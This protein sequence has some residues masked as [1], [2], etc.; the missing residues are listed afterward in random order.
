MDEIRETQDEARQSLARSLADI[1]GGGN[2]VDWFEGAPEF[3]DAE[4]VSLL[5][6][7]EGPSR[8]RIALDVRGRRAIVTIEMTAWIDVDVRG[9]NRQNVVDA[10]ALRR[11]DE[12]EIQPWEVGV[13]CQPGVW[14]IELGPCFGAYGTIRADI[15]QIVIEPLP[16]RPIENDW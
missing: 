3:G 15:A 1:P 4:I 16:E 6:D 7:R 8:L 11:A 14:L 5:L 2:V 10:L 9:F 13:G 12:R